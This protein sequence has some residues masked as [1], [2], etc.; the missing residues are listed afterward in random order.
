MGKTERPVIGITMGD[1][2][3]IG[4][5]ITARL[6]DSSWVHTVC[7]PVVIGDRCAME[8][9]L[10]QIKSQKEIHVI[11]DMTEAGYGETG[12]SGTGYGEGQIPLIDLNR[13]KRGTYRLGEIS[14]DCGDAAF[15]Y[16][17]KAIELAMEKMVDATVTAPINKEALNL[18]GRHYSGHTEIYAE[19]TKTHDYAMMLAYGSM[20]VAHVS[21]HVSLKEACD[22]VKKDRVL[23][24]IRLAGEACRDMGI[25]SPKIVVAGLNPHCGEG[26]LFGTEEALEIRP[27]I[28]EARRE[29]L[30]VSGPVP[31]DTV[32][33]KLKGGVYDICVCMYHDQGHIP[34]KL[35]GF[36][37]KDGRQ[38]G[39]VN[40]INM[41]LGLPVIRVSVDHGTAFDIAGKNL[42]SEASLISAVEYAVTMAKARS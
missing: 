12:Y 31:P 29:G 10:A 9:A 37:W 32:F 2:A 11:R 41:T 38:S 33:C 3:G 36:Q 34:V 15:L 21:T 18:A 5:E 20:R 16:V 27:A 40:G 42:A 22:R 8:D 24:V 19:Y 13:L 6:M 25:A 26:G 1:P 14:A 23:T 17:K 7:R 4:P 30:C 28:E 39:E 35:A